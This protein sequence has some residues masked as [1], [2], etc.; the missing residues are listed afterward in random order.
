[1]SNNTVTNPMDIT[2][3]LS[4]LM[5]TMREN[6][7]EE[8]MKLKTD[9]VQ[10]K[11][12]DAKEPARKTPLKLARNRATSSPNK[13][14]MGLA[15]MSEDSDIV[16]GNI[17]VLEGDKENFISGAGLT[18]PEPPRSVNPRHRSVVESAS[19]ELPRVSPP[20]LPLYDSPASSSTVTR[21]QVMEVMSPTIEEMERTLG[22]NPNSPGLMF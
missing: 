20:S 21:D 18:F 11:L 8:F 16:P 5:R 13:T 12:V 14:I 17:E 15:D 4:P 10:S 22:I 9:L 1:M 6:M 7:Q 19:P 2:S 3:L